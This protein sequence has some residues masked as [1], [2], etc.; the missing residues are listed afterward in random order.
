MWA[1]GKTR[2]KLVRIGEWNVVL[3]QRGVKYIDEG[4]IMTSGGIS[5]EINMS[6]YIVKKL[7]GEEVARTIAKRMEYDVDI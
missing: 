3:V 7:L 2:Q 1:S 6:F 5:A 4:S